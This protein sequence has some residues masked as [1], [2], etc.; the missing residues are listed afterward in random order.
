VDCVNKAEHFLSGLALSCQVLEGK[1]FAEGMQVGTCKESIACNHI[2]H[3]HLCQYS[4]REIT[5]VWGM[6]DRAAVFTGPELAYRVNILVR[7]EL[8]MRLPVAAAL[9]PH[10][11]QPRECKQDERCSAY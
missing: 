2:V 10:G 11:A 4:A 1:H 7:G 8:F 5:N 6:A 3:P 9:T